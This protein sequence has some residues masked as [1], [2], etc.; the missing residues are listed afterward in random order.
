MRYDILKLTLAALL[1]SWPRV[2]PAANAAAEALAAAKPVI[3]VQD[4][5]GFGAYAGYLEETFGLS[6][7]DAAD[8]MA[9]PGAR[10]FL[11]VENDALD[12]WQNN[13]RAWENYL[14]RQVQG[15]ARATEKTIRR[16]I[17]RH[18]AV[19]RFYQFPQMSNR[20]R[21]VRSDFLAD[22]FKSGG[23]EKFWE[24]YPGSSGLISFT[25]IGWSD[26]QREAVFAVRMACGERCGY[27]DLVMMRYI[28]K[29]WHLIYK[30]PLP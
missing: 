14:L 26:D 15:Q 23:W 13:R 7:A 24:R 12:S 9:L 5:P 25:G 6:Q 29:K 4:W 10:K 3:A 21:L 19:L 1:A 18:P 22:I 8:A 16:Y 27:R 2:L 17:Y 30:V 28:E 11:V 20:L